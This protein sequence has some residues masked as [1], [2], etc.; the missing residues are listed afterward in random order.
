MSVNNT[1]KVDVATT[2]KITMEAIVANVE[3]VFRCTIGRLA[4]V[5]FIAT[6]I[7]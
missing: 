6:V 1:I 2:V 5:T 3:Q 4:K 7:K